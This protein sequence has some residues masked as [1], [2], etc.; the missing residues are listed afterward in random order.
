MTAPILPHHPILRAASR[1][2]P[3][4]T[5]PPLPEILK[6]AGRA[7]ETSPAMITVT[8]GPDHVLAYQNATSARVLGTRELGLPL[9][10]AFPELGR[11]SL[12]S[13]DRVLQTGE[14]LDMRHR[15]VRV[16]DV[17]GAPLILHYVVA[18][19]GSGPPHAG[20]VMTAVDV[21]S[22]SRAE[23][24]AA[25]ATL[26][27]EISERMNASVDPDAALQALTDRLVP[28]VA[29]LAGVYVISAA[30]PE[31]GPPPAAQAV[32]FT[33]GTDLLA[34]AGPP[35][36]PSPREGPSPW[37]A[38]LAAGHT[39]LIDLASLPEEQTDPAN[40]AWVE[41]AGAHSVA[42]VPLVIAGELAGALLLLAAGPRPRYLQSDVAFLEDVTARA[43]AAVAHLRSYQ[44]QRQIALNLQQ[45]LLPSTPP[46][47]PGFDVAARYVA[48]SS[49]VE[50]G[51]DWWDVHHLGD[52]RIG[53]GVGDVSG[54]GV[55]AAVL[56]GQ[57]RSGMRAAAHADLGPARILT[58]LDAQVQELVHVGSDPHEPMPPKYATAAYA[59]VEPADGG[60][61]RIANAGH[62]PLLLRYPT[63]EVVQS[64]APP[65]APLG[66]GLGDYVEITL[67][68]P[69]GSILLA[70]T[71]GLA[72]SRT[73]PLDTGIAQLA[74]D[75]AAFDPDEELDA[76]ADAMLAHADSIDDT[77]LVLLRSHRR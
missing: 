27:T 23:Q 12:S 70:Y 5:V 71:D 37:D 53:I 17:H 24:S 69:P 51:G 8:W 11:G 6:A 38:A 1:Y 73:R 66:L 59:I 26:V 65:G 18:P 40:A 31:G 44:Q 45:A 19:L 35:P 36:P 60:H 34:A 46:T 15:E 28:T 50:V 76:L 33:L 61:L 4:V 32:A 13:L 52:G 41:A 7:W 74:G 20:V 25:R 30:P 10:V 2:G 9:D 75:L 63:G 16:L 57:A 47:L 14:V 3:E 77:A 42:V 68:F 22:E 56:M 21:T 48:G 64:A 54:R 29:D 49:D 62:P 67:P 43:G 58:V 72:E 55:P 39:V